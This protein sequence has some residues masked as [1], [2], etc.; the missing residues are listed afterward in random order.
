M[1]FALAPGIGFCIAGKQA[2][3]FNPATDDYLCL[4]VDAT[5]RLQLALASCEKPEG[6]ND[7]FSSL[8]EAGLAVENSSPD[9][10]FEPKTQ[11]V[12][13]SIHGQ[14]P[15][16]TSPLMLI[17]ALTDQ[18]GAERDLKL[19]GL[20]NTLRALS[21]ARNG[22]G[23]LRECDAEPLMRISHAF[24]LS[25]RFLPTT[26]KCLS[27]SIALTRRLLSNG[28]GA[29]LVLGVRTMPFVAHAWVQINDLVLND[30]AEDVQRYTPIWV[31]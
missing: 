2:A 10:A 7:L 20:G 24:Y 6:H 19:H 22:H 17:H 16:Q 30:Y 14:A 1:G 12:V 21:A 26:N 31:V 29:N 25:K 15:K 28:I 9:M 4:S 23:A 3:F 18:L 11:T 27:R 5:Q 8:V 13:R